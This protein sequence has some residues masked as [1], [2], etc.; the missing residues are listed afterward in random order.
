MAKNGGGGS[1][2]AGRPQLHEVKPRELVGR[3]VIARFECQFRAAALECL[4]L[5]EGKAFDRVYCD[6]QEDFVIRESLH[7]GS[8]YHFVQ[9]KTKGAKKHQWS[10]LEL[11]GVPQKLPAVVKAAHAPGGCVGKAATSEQLKKIRGSFVGKLLEHTVNF[12]DACKTVTFLTNVYLEDQVEQIS[13]AIRI[14]DVSERTVRYLADNYSAIF[15]ITHPFEMSIAHACI[16]KL[17]LSAGHDYLDPHHPHFESKAVKAVWDFSEIDLTHT[18][19]IELVTKLLGL[20]QKKSSRKMLHEL[21]SEDLDDFAGV[22]V[23]DLLDLLPIS[24]GAYQNFL[25]EGDSN[26][27]K[28][29]SILQR[30]L[31]QA[32]ANPELIETASRWKIS[33]DTWFRTYRHTYE[34]EISFLQHALNGIYVRWARGEVSF[35]GLQVEVDALKS[36]LSTNSL[37]LALTEEMLTGG[38]L[39]E[40]VRSESR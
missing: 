38:V 6:Y 1:D 17:R 34:R 10:R 8:A 37:G 11:F 5:L 2:E 26:A 24:R 15:G 7:E 20:V 19:G 28:N 39:A 40:L 9:V 29:A 25:S 36:K 3:E 18:E 16:G 21:T 14:G 31:G 33:W 13:E 27:L 23:D 35:S 32:G 12:S 30:K 22:G 4:R